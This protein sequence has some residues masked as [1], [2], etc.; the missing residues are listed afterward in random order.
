MFTFIYLF[1]CLLT[2]HNV[3]CAIMIRPNSE[4]SPINTYLTM[5]FCGILVFLSI[6]S[7]D[8]S[9]SGLTKKQIYLQVKISF[10]LMKTHII[11][12]ELDYAKNRIARIPPRHFNSRL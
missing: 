4:I 8:A 3:T 11:I 7:V 9:S 6:S 2:K 1:A 12:F 5:L 10:V